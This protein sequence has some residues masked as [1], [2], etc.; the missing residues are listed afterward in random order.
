VALASQ[1]YLT[2]FKYGQVNPVVWHVAEIRDIAGICH[3][4]TLQLRQDTEGAVQFLESALADH[5][6]SARLRRR[7]IEIFIQQA[8]RDA[9]L[10]HANAMPSTTP[11]LEAF[12]SAVRGACFA[13]QKNLIA[14]KAYLHAGYSHGCRDPICLKWLVLCLLALGDEQA[15]RPILEVWKQLEP[16]NPEIDK[17]LAPLPAPTGIPAATWRVDAGSDGSLL[18]PVRPVEAVRS[19]GW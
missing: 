7:L 15:A 18:G 12:R 2:A 13:V 3:S 4:L 17:L 16:R 5:P 1:A 19:V 8:N 10:A 14:A 11:H 9:A 6:E